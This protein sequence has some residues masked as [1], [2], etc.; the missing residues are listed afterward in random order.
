MPADDMSKAQFQ[1]D[2]QDPEEVTLCVTCYVNDKLDKN[3]ECKA[4]AK[5]AEY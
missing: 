4:C 2:N 5:S 1:Y 3:G